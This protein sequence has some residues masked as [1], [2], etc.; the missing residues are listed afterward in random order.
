M[1]S[2]TTLTA[3][4]PEQPSALRTGIDNSTRVIIGGCLKSVYKLSSM[5]LDLSPHT[6]IISYF[7]VPRITVTSL[8]T[9]WMTTPVHCSQMKLTTHHYQEQVMQI[10]SRDYLDVRQIHLEVAVKQAH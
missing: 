7:T 10:T 5:L 1:S 2:L 8:H 4:W 3:S 6:K 9:S